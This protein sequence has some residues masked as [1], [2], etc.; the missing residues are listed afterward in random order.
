MKKLFVALSF[1]FLT[2]LSAHIIKT[3][4]TL[5][6][7][8]QN[9]PI[10]DI[11]TPSEWKET[12]VIEGSIPIMFFDEKGNYDVRR[13]LK[14]LNTRV[15]TTQPFAIICRTGSRT[16]MV[17]RFLSNEL[18]YD[19]IDIVGGIIEAKKRGFPITPLEAHR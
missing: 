16:A 17:A 12:G 9:I 10:V 11:R 19:V 18:G 3:F 13:F 5:K 6:L 1:L 7:L 2:Q 4:P 14:E 8:E 15:D